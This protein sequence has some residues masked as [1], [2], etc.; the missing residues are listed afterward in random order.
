MFLF[1]V[2]VFDAPFFHFSPYAT[3]RECSNDIVLLYILSRFMGML[4]SLSATI[5]A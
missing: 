1:C 2:S 5:P 4:S 3:S